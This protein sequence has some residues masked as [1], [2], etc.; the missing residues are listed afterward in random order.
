MFPYLLTDLQ[1]E[2][3]H[4]FLQQHSAL[5]AV[6]P[7]WAVQIVVLPQGKGL[8]ELYEKDAR[9]ALQPV[10]ARIAYSGPS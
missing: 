10:R 8:A 5:L 9:Y 7:K 4:W 1:K 6:L 2:D 3:F